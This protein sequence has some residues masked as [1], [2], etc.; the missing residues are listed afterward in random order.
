MKSEEVTASN[1]SLFF[2]VYFLLFKTLA[3]LVKDPVL[4]SGSL[5]SNLDPF[6]QYSDED[7]WK[8]LQLA[9]LGSLVSAL[10]HK[11]HHYCC[12]GGENFRCV[13]ASL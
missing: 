1:F 4:F 9:H 11:L 6:Q 12:E 2:F 7:V 13:T 10:P 5:R 8:A 3:C